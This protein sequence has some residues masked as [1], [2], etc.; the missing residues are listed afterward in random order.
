[1]QA[2]VLAVSLLGLL[3]MSGHADDARRALAQSRLES[4][5]GYLRVEKPKRAS[6]L[7][8][9]NLSL[10]QPGPG[11]AAQVEVT[12]SWALRIDVDRYRPKFPGATGR[13][14]IDTVTLYLSFASL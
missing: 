7:Q 5:L 14:S 11:F 10:W 2:R 9:D 12:K 13:E 6:E 8:R 1:M 3:P 4:A